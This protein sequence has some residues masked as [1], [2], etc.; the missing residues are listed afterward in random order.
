MHASRTLWAS[1]GC[2]SN[3]ALSPSRLNHPWLPIGTKC[4]LRSVWFLD[5]HVGWAA[6]GFSRPYTHTSTGVLLRTKDGGRTWTAIA[7]RMLPSL[8]K[9]RFFDPQNGF[10]IGATSAVFRH[11]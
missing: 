7:E 8:A 9:I 6:G 1:M 3:R 4:P 5:E 10:A 11:I 2:W